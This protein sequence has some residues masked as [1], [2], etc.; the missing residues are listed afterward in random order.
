M[1][2][3]SATQNNY[4]EYDKSLQTLK[5]VNELVS[6]FGDESDIS[7]DESDSERTEECENSD[8]CLSDLSN[9]GV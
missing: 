2:S 8:I 4:S 7:G 9:T 3:L 5:R 6:Q 1:K